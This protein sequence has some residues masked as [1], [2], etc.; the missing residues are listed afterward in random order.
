MEAKRLTPATGPRPTSNWIVLWGSL[1]LL[2]LLVGL[3]LALLWAPEEATM[4]IYQR[5]FYY[6]VPAAITAFVAFF[7]NLVASVVYLL[8]RSRIADAWAVASAEVGVVFL[9]INLIT[10]P[11][12]A[13]P[14][15]GIWWTWDA[16]LTLDL[17][18]WVMYVSY[19][20]LRQLTPRGELQPRLA[21]AL[22]CFFFVDVPINYMAIRWWHTQHPQPVIFGGPGSGLA[23][24]MYVALAICWM[25]FMALGYVLLRLRIE[26][27]MDRHA[28]DDAQRALLLEDVGG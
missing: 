1:T 14:I 9:T 19:L 20:L 2:L 5:I 21:A 24:P 22:A 11:I 26:Q 8:R 23:P 18:L 3:Y 6:H 13:K 16:R 28:L 27:E 17:V 12:W 7:I 15:W 25:A 10:G 4:G